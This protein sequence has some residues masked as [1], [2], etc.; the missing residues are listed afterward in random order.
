MNEKKKLKKLT[1][2]KETI[3]QLNQQAMN[4]LRGGCTNSVTCGN[5]GTETIGSCITCETCLECISYGPYCDVW[6][7]GYGDDSICMSVNTI[8]C[9]DWCKGRG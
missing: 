5:Q 7:I 8:A 3:A 2:K 9:G 4:D 1:L 6:S